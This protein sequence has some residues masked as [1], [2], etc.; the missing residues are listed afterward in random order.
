MCY[1]YREKSL[2][3]E[4]N[5]EMLKHY[6]QMLLNYHQEKA[7]LD[8]AFEMAKDGDFEKVRSVTVEDVFKSVTKLYSLKHTGAKIK[9][10]Y[11]KQ[12]SA[13]SHELRFEEEYVHRKTTKQ[14]RWLRLIFGIGKSR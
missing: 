2:G 7:I 6:E 1:I 14:S 11:D 5:K 8:K 4:C 9:E 12:E 10:L 13:R 3:D